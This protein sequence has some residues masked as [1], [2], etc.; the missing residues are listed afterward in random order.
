MVNFIA[1]IAILAAVPAIAE[2][3][4]RKSVGVEGANDDY[5]P[6]GLNVKKGD[7]V[8]IGA[9]GVVSTGAFNGRTD[10]NG[11]FGRCGESDTDGALMYKIGPTAAQRP[12]STSS[13][14]RRT[15]AN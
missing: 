3:I 5:T 10:P 2:S 7:L 12:A 9:S 15:T 8:L 1:A 13:S 11:H 4:E 14:L 6:T